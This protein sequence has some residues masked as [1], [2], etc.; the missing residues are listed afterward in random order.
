MAAEPLA[1]LIGRN[2][3]RIR[4]DANLTLDRVASE[5]SALG[6]AWSHSRVA[7]FERGD[8]SPTLPIILVVC[9]A[10]ARL[11]DKD[12]TLADLTASVD[13]VQITEGLA[14]EAS[15]V[16]AVLSGASA[17]TI[18]PPDPFARPQD[19]PEDRR[20]AFNTGRAERDLAQ[21]LGEDLRLVSIA[22]AQLWGK[23]YSEERDHRAGPDASP[24]AKGRIS[25][26][27]KTELAE[28]LEEAHQHDARFSEA[29]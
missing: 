14:A 15:A 11:L 8:V 5:V 3:R 9:A 19:S 25:R 1:T 13:R 18:A 29:D 27:L 12:V 28:F 10:L 17:A 4:S 20:V 21:T 7:A 23:S 16:S 26:T 6:H 22:S 24:Q 2:A